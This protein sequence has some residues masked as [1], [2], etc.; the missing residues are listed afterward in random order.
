M[1]EKAINWNDVSRERKA[2]IANSINLYGDGQHPAA[3]ATNLDYFDT[4]YVVECMCSRSIAQA[5]AL[6]MK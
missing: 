1:A 3:S 2:C 6:R 4:T 5:R